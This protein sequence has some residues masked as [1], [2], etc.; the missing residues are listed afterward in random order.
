MYGENIN[1][2]S[3]GK[4]LMQILLAEFNHKD[5]Q[6]EPSQEEVQIAEELYI[7]FAKITTNYKFVEEYENEFG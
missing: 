1:P 6:A 7:K 5:P 3:V 2:I 4:A